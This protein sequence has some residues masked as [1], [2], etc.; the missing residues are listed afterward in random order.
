MCFFL[1]FNGIERLETFFFIPKCAPFPNTNFWLFSALKTCSEF[2]KERE[3]AK[4]RGDFQKHRE[5]QQMEED[6][7]GYLDWITQAEDL[8]AEPTQG[9]VGLPGVAINSNSKDNGTG[10]NTEPTRKTSEVIWGVLKS[11]MVP[12]ILHENGN[13]QGILDVSGFKSFQ[14]C[15][16]SASST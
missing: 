12:M 2:S 14:S 6:L 10:S 3:K 15:L 11:S 5:R 4:S 13:S 8:D 9:S 1:S 16:L 7:R